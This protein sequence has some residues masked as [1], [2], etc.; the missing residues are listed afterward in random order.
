MAKFIN[1][2]PHNHVL[3]TEEKRGGKIGS[4]IQ[5]IFPGVDFQRLL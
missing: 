3:K 4:I 2:S 5:E 1:L